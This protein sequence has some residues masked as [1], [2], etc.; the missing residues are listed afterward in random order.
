MHKCKNIDVDNPVFSLFQELN[1]LDD[2]R[3]VSSLLR[4]GIDLLNDFTS[5][6]PVAEILK[7]RLALVAWT[8]GDKTWGIITRSQEQNFPESLVCS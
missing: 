1:A 3:G 6:K 8:L 2:L 7:K 4:H 5:N